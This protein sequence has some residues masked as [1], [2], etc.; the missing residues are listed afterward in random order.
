MGN[1]TCTAYAK[2]AYD[3][4][5]ETSPKTNDKAEYD[6]RAAWVPMWRVFIT[7]FCQGRLVM[8][9][10]RCGG[11]NTPLHFPDKRSDMKRKT[12]RKMNDE[13]TG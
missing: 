8:P 12:L 1:L 4:C 10:N 7:V 13:K 5:S 3:A 9:P 11:E 2:S 6:D